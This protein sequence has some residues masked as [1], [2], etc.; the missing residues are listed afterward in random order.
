MVLG[1]RIAAP[2]VTSA[3]AIGSGSMSVSYTVNL[4][5][6]SPDG[7]LPDISPGEVVREV[8]KYLS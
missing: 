8:Y 3:V 1:A 7:N 6:T 4:T 5:N 2:K